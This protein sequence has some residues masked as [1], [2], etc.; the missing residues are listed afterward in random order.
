MSVEL[1][2][3][4]IDTAARLTLP[5]FKIDTLKE[6]VEG[7]KT[8][9]YIFD[10]NRLIENYNR[11]RRF[12]PEF[13]VFY[14][15]K[16]NPMEEVIDTLNSE[17]SCFDAATIGEIEILRSRQVSPE[18]ILYTHPVKLP[19]TIQRAV[20]LGIG[21]FTFDS[22]EEFKDLVENAP[23]QKY[24]LRVLPTLQGG[25][26]DYADKFGASRNS[27]RT[28]FEYAIDNGLSIYGLSFHVGSQ[29]MSLEPWQVA[30]DLCK[31]T[32]D[33]YG[34][35]MLA[36]RVVNMGSGFPHPYKTLQTLPLPSIAEHIH[37]QIKDF[38]EGT[39]FWAEPGRILVA[40]IGILVCTVLRNIKREENR[41]LYIDTSVYNGLIEILESKG[42]LTY[43]I[44][45]LTQ[46]NETP[47]NVAGNTLDPDDT[48]AVGVSLPEDLKAG[49]RVI[50]RDVGAYTTSFFTAYHALP[51]PEIM[52]T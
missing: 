45:S 24:Y 9:L 22:L 30:L 36:L 38:R 50:V 40:D 41:W 6:F 25:F 28:I 32:I 3:N 29:N 14:S 16:T 51:E 4:Q 35:T 34:D 39:E 37:Q 48:I 47:C 18:Q 10:L 23:G 44:E 5:N 26:Y 12:F 1:T 43:R 8:P 13:K 7:K 52:L 27:I 19:Q 46:G 42:Q 31:E 21:R 15:V 33:R 17:G 11:F 2:P 49:D 20:H